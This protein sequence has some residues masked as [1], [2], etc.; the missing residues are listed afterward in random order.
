MRR[1]L[2]RLR[3]CAGGEAGGG[4]GCTGDWKRLGA[5][6]PPGLRRA[7]RAARRRAAVAELLDLIEWC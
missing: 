7:L 5:E 1:R 4:E 6:R 3:K 2:W